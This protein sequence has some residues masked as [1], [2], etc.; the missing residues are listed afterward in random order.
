MSRRYSTLQERIERNCYMDP[1][2]GCW[3]WLGKAAT[4]RG[5]SLRARI[6]VW[7]DG[8][9][10]TLSVTRLVLRLFKGVRLRRNQEAG[11]THDNGG[12]LCVCPHHLV[13]QSRLVN[14]RQEAA[15]R[16]AR[17]EPR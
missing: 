15:A 10:R 9:H 12:T 1:M 4:G 11:H 17:K 14:Q 8:E 3:I 13:P 7:V 5:G 16:K 2:T 6:N